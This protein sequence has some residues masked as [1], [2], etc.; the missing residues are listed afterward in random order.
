MNEITPFL[1][2]HWVLSLAFLVIAFAIIVLEMR[3]KTGD[4]SRINTMQA[5]ELMN[6]HNAVVVDI[7][8]KVQYQKGHI[9]NAVHC[10]KDDMEASLKVLSAYKNSPVI[11]VCY[12][13]Q[14][15]AVFATKLRQAGFQAKVLAGGMD[16]WKAANLPIEK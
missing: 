9:I 16:G 11:V 5:I 7:R 12:V 2:Q 1:M 6:H 14:P 10:S 3:E 13:G 4:G 15:A 8:D